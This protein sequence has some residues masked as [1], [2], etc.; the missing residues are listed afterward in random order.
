METFEVESCIRGYH[1]FKSIWNA[2]TGEELNCLRETTNTEDP[3]AVAVK[4]GSA[5][6]DHVPRKI[7]AACALFLRR[8]GTIRCTITGSRRFSADLPQGGLEVPCTLIFRGEPKDVAKMRKLVVPVT[9]TKSSAPDET[10]N[11]PPNKKRKV[12]SEV[13]DVDKVVFTTVQS[14][15]PWL[16]LKGI[17]L[18][19]TDRSIIT[20]GNM[21][22]DKHINFAQEILKMQF[23]NLKGLQSTLVL[24]KHQKLPA[25]SQYLQIVHCRGNHWI[26]VSN[27]H[28]SPKVLQVFDSLYSSVDG[29][30][31]KLLT[32]LFG[33]G[34]VIEMGN[35]PLQNGTADCGVFAIATCV[36]LANHRQPEKKLVQE[37]MR[38]HLVK[39]FE[40]F[41]LT[42]FPC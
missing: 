40:N 32:K 9:S 37:K 19:E 15:K 3:Y 5:V 14:P 33:E 21:L 39:C 27:I 38:D 11:K 35:C 1:V 16:S 18:T 25:T 41:T 22:T 2:T 34:V 13:V 8:K 30:T 4:R 23:H 17:E 28:S 12:S 29:M 36:A 7:S 42:A 6:V 20:S 10:E 26:V 24:S 31:M